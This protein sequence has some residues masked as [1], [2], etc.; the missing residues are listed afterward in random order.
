MNATDTGS[1]YPL[2]LL[3][4]GILV[5][6]TAVYLAVRDWRERGSLEG[7][8]TVIGIPLTIVGFAALW[9]VMYVSGVSLPY[10]LRSLLAAVLLGVAFGYAF[11]YLV[12]G[13]VDH[14]RG[15]RSRSYLG[16]MWQLVVAAWGMSLL[17]TTLIESLLNG[18]FEPGKHQLSSHLMWLSVIL[19]WALIPFFLKRRLASE[20]RSET[21]IAENRAFMARLFAKKR[22]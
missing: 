15:L 9:Y 3:I 17:W 13:A 12:A 6:A 11:A 21:L 7:L 2:S 14:V 5:F 8:W 20:L 10:R 19:G 16:Y 1:G 22:E 4:P 18:P